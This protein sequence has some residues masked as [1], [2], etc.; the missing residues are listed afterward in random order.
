[1][2]GLSRPCCSLQ[3]TWIKQSFE[4]G[5][6][7]TSFARGLLVLTDKRPSCP[8]QLSIFWNIVH[9]G[10]NVFWSNAL[11]P[12]WTGPSP[13]GGP[14][15]PG[16]HLKSVP[17]HFTFGPWL[18]YT[19]NTAF[20]KCA[21]PSGFW[22]LPLVFGPPAAKSWR[23]ACF[24]KQR[25]VFTHYNC[26]RGRLWKQSSLL[27]HCSCSWGPFEGRVLNYDVVRKISYER[28]INFSPKMRNI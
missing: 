26:C 9:I 3:V 7:R 10:L 2:S 23:R 6:L 18:L 24:W 20:K 25:T 14:M 15:V 13:V 12:F 1:M 28:L 21:P 11:G 16:P 8:M 19:S 22:P 27:A 5:V 17:P 4:V